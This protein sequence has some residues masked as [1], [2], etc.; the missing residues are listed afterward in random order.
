MQDSRVQVELPAVCLPAQGPH[1][2]SPPMWGFLHPIPL[3][4]RV[5][6]DPQF[7]ASPA[8]RP[9]GLEGWEGP[10]IQG[11]AGGAVSS[12][13]GAGLGLCLARINALDLGGRH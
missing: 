7:L 6:A 8:C 3:S 2:F 9:A 12:S 5:F 11:E 10:G 13:L 4:E 1:Y